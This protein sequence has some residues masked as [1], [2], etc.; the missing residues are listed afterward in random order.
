MRG[1]ARRGAVEARRAHNPKVASSNLAAATKRITEEE[2]PGL[3]FFFQFGAEAPTLTD[4]CR[5]DCPLRTLRQRDRSVLRQQLL[6]PLQTQPVLEGR[7][8]RQGRDISA[9]HTVNHVGNLNPAPLL[10]A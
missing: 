2:P 8:H 6:E 3:L 10:P 4:L 7:Q 5:D 1:C 9:P